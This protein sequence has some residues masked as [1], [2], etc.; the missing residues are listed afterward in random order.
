MS[1]SVKI[2]WLTLLYSVQ[3]MFLSDVSILKSFVR[4]WP[5]VSYELYNIY[6]FLYVIAGVATPQYFAVLDETF[7]KKNLR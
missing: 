5:N 2:S 1:S 7:M 3:Y 6:G 4:D